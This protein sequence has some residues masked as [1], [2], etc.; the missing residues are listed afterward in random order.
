MLQLS[1][2]DLAMKFGD[3]LLFAIA[4]LTLNQNQTIY[5]KGQNGAG[6]TTLMKLIAGLISPTKGKIQWQD[7]KKHPWW[8]RHPQLGQIVYLHQHPYLFEGSVK[9]NLGYGKQFSQLEADV[10]EARQ[11]QAISMA[12]LSHLLDAKASNLSGGERQRLAIARAWIIQ[13]AILLLDEPVSNM[14]DIS[15]SL[16]LTMIKALKEQGTGMVISSHQISGLTE[17]CQQVWLLENQSVTC[18]DPNVEQLTLRQEIA[19]VNSN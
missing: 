4:Y 16:V 6:K 17:L 11:Q 3:R 5:L 14:D 1:I 13:P 8:Q 9:F 12:R 2:T 7:D 15:Q 18:L 19:Y 10:L